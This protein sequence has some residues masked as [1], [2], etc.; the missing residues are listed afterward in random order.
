MMLRIEVPFDR[1]SYA[2][3]EYTNHTSTTPLAL[4]H[5]FTG[6]ADSWRENMGYFSIDRR[7][8]AVDLPGHGET[9]SPDE[10][11][12]YTAENTVSALQHLLHGQQHLLGYS[13]GGRMAL[14]YALTYPERV[15]TLILESASPGIVDPVERIARIQSDSDL[16]DRIERG[17]I[18][19][20]VNYWENIPLFST[21]KRLPVETRQQ[22]REQRLKNNPRGLA[23]SLRGFGAGVMPPLWYELGELNMPILLIAGALDTKYVEIAHQMAARMKNARVEIIPDAGHT[24]HLEQPSQFRAVVNNFM[25][26]R[27]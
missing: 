16:A 8:R 5:G 14:T 17:G 18:E 19:A 27:E 2:G 15:E 9:S 23:N 25:R 10:V 22:V 11:E 13:M 20:F 7:V 1:I 24:V 4:L 12:E 6:S 21:Q 26:E 3:I